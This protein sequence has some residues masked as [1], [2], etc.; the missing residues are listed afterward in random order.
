MVILVDYSRDDAFS[1]NRSQIGHV[2]D[3]L[4]LHIRGR[5][6]PGL[7]RRVTVSILRDLF[8]VRSVKRGMKLEE[9]FEKIGLARKSYDDALKKYGRLTREAL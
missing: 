8:V 2:P 6:R 9:A 4:R 1:A 7:V 3:E 5:C